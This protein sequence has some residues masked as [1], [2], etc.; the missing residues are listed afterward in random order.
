M[1]VIYTTLFH[2]KIKGNGCCTL[3]FLI[4]KLKLLLQ[5][6]ISV[7]CNR[8]FLKI[9]RDIRFYGPFTFLTEAKENETLK[10]TSDL[11][12]LNYVLFYL[13]VRVPFY[14][15]RSKQVMELS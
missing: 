6:T 15:L 1:A 2:I 3:S 11:V 13:Q 14:L 8:F 5:I 4:A 10:F 9:K 7:L 12:N